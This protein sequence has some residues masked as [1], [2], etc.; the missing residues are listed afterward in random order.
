MPNTEIYATKLC[1]MR[2]YMQIFLHY[3]QEVVRIVRNWPSKVLRI[4]YNLAYEVLRI[5]QKP[6]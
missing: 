2:N 4:V 5:V 1:K 3:D 6:S